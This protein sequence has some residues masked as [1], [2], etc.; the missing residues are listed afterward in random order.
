MQRQRVS[1]RN[2]QGHSRVAFLPY[3][4]V[5][6]KA[7]IPRNTD[8]TPVTLGG[9]IKKQRLRLG[10]GQREAGERLGVTAS[11][12]LNWEKGYTEPI[13]EDMPAIIQFLGYYPFPEPM[14]LG[15]RMLAKR[16]CMG[17]TIKRAAEALG[18]DEDTWGEWERTGTVAWPRYQ[19]CLD[20]FLISQAYQ[21]NV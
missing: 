1:P 21:V 18:V 20:W 13:V 6:R 11:T 19:K 16:R 2:P 4:K 9:H 8:F 10:L 17:W 14:S 5:T 7:L 12:V 15:E 3:V